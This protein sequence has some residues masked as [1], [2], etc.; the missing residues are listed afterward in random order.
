MR[1]SD[2]AHQSI[3]VEVAT[4]RLLNSELSVLTPPFLSGL[5]PGF[6]SLIAKGEEVRDSTSLARNGNNI[7]RPSDTG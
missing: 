3:A 4:M 6:L 5:L 7:A 1:C 2:S